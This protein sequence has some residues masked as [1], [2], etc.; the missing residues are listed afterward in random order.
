[1]FSLQKRRQITSLFLGGI[2]L[3]GMI[4]LGVFLS[5]P[6]E[7]GNQFLIGLSRARFAI[8]LVFLLLL[9]AVM[10]AAV[11]TF[12]AKAGWQKRVEIPLDGLLSKPIGLFNVLTLL[13]II[14]VGSGSFLLLNLI[15]IA[16][17]IIFLEGMITRLSS[18]LGWIFVASILL[19]LLLVIQYADI[20]RKKG[21]ITPLK[22]TLWGLLLLGA[23]ILLLIDYRQAAYVLSLRKAEFPLIWLGFFFLLAGITSQL[24]TG[25]RFQEGLN[26]ILLLSGIFLTTFVIYEHIAAWIGWE[27]TR[28]TYW[29][30]LADQILRGKLFL[31]NPPTTHDLA[32]FNGN[33]Y[34]PMP[35]LP[36]II[37]APLAA[38]VGGGNINTA[39]FSMF[40]S[41]IN[42]MLMFMILDALINRKWIKISRKD[43][44]WLVLLF[45][46][47]TNHLWV[48]INGR[49]WFVSQVLTVTMLEIGTLAVL[50]SWSPWAIGTCLA[51]AIT[52]RPNSL[53]FWP[54][55]FAISLQILQENGIKFDLKK[56]VAWIVKSALPMV[57]A[58]TGLLLYNYVRFGNFMDFGY[59]LLNGD[60]TIVEN[61][62][63]FGIFSTHFIA[64]NLEVMFLYLPVIQ[65]GSQW[66]ISPSG[67]GMSIFLATPPLIYL[68]HHY[69]RKWWI[70]G[71]WL[72]V[73]LIF[74]LLV[75][76]HNT[77]AHQFG[78]R[79]ILDAIIPLMT[80]LAVA[81]DKKVPW[82]FIMLT[83]ISIIINIY[84][85]AWFMNA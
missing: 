58:V 12:T 63:T 23:Y 31:E 47:G 43:A 33:W 60:P 73:G 57:F 13:Y 7:L 36:A 54:F 46:F 66:P 3:T 61:A 78:Y 34:I 42:C 64:H 80:L 6:S 37:M 38:I 53:M 39:D 21:F 9:I 74:I 76:Y 81:L 71:S 26:N 45:A 24:A 50:K 20:I 16:K 4:L 72:T 83:I 75:L 11:F 32:L 10:M 14:L 65:L 59:T 27:N 17:P 5:Q 29:N 84:G 40:F 41:A 70:M 69:D 44:L 28:Y 48:G 62:R 67:A 15:P 25:S 79:Y 35:P 68:I 30:L 8:G 49:A 55:P 19:M 1:M 85:A 52:A 51:L 2:S 77:G 82:H 56:Q 18:M 22:I